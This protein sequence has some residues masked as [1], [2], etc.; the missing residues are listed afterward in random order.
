M[1][2]RESIISLPLRLMRSTVSETA[3]RSHCEECENRLGTLF[4]SLP[5]EL[6]VQTICNLQTLT[7][8]LALRRVSRSLAAL[9]D[10]N[11]FAVTNVSLSRNPA[12]IADT[13]WKG[14]Y[15]LPHPM[16]DSK[17]LLELQRRQTI[18]NG[19]CQL[20]GD[21]V[22]DKIYR[23]KS[24]AKRQQ[25]F[26]PKRRSMEEHF[27]LPM[28]ILYH[29]LENTFH[30]ILQHTK[31]PDEGHPVSVTV[32]RTNCIKQYPSDSLLP[33]FQLCRIFFS[34]YRQKLRPPSYAGS[35]ERKCRGWDRTPA[36]QVEMSRVIVF[37]G[38]EAMYRIIKTSRYTERIDAMHN[39][40]DSIEES[41][42]H[43]YGSATSAGDSN[44]SMPDDPTSTTYNLESL[45]TQCE[46]FLDAA[47]QRLLE[48][49]V[50]DQTSD[51]QDPY[52]Y[53]ENTFF[54][55]P[56]LQNDMAPLFPAQA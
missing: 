33:A 23:I 52:S 44:I 30:C 41:S 37:G 47:R 29:F 22:Q 50:V 8:I 45:T 25:Q 12:G 15:P 27:R 1:G 28:L 38:V 54:Q 18:I 7:E 26:A 51:I 21:F 31:L 42:P 2:R 35:L 46:V 40:L 3:D 4:C 24:S 39:F 48:E 13:V 20:V 19:A 55:S 53:L 10:R 6:Q 11:A 14:L 32:R 16:D 56:N 9:V 36:T 5:T 17:Y 43:R 49:R 34:V